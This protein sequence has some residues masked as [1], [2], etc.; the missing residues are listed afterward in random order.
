MAEHRRAKHRGYEVEVMVDDNGPSTVTVNGED[1]PVRRLEGG[2]AVAYL[3][4]V[5][6][7]LEAAK[8]YVNRLPVAKG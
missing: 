3:E 7:L 2:F 4:P 5:A 6:D 8:L 1:V